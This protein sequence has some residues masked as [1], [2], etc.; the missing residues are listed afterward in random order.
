MTRLSVFDR[1]GPLPVGEGQQAAAPQGCLPPPP[2]LPPPKQ[3][4]ALQHPLIAKQLAACQLEAAS[5]SSCCPPAAPP[6]Q[7]R[8]RQAGRGGGS[9]APRSCQANPHA[10]KPLPGQQQWRRRQGRRGSR[11]DAP[12]SSAAS[13]GAAEQL[14][15]RLRR[16]QAERDASDEALAAMAAQTQVG[17]GWHDRNTQVCGCTSCHA[18]QGDCNG[19]HCSA[20]AGKT[21]SPSLPHACGTPLPMQALLAEKAALAVQ[22][23]ALEAQ[24]RQLE[25]QLNYL[26][27]AEVSGSGAVGWMA[28]GHRACI[29][30]QPCRCQW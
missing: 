9:N 28:E 23:A 21:P 29:Q 6:Y 5:T 14:Q 11:N 7:H 16:L 17:G 12:S 2:G 1:L 26:L 10:A 4:L 30:Q 13:P 8:Q 19:G 20:L 3:C 24:K 15:A 18:S 25:E 22:A 27:P